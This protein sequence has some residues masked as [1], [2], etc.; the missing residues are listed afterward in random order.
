MTLVVAICNFYTE[1]WARIWQQNIRIQRKQHF[2]LSLR[3]D[4]VIRA[5]SASKKS[6]LS[7]RNEISDFHCLLPWYRYMF[8]KEKRK[9]DLK[10]YK[11]VETFKR[12]RTICTANTVCIC[13]WKSVMCY[14]KLLIYFEKNKKIPRFTRFGLTFRTL[15]VLHICD[16]LLSDA[17]W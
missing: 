16:S 11:S 17:Y 6:T 5:R 4:V 14:V 1:L 10:T 15:M 9:I 8:L 3:P 12:F 13:S 7:H 2:K